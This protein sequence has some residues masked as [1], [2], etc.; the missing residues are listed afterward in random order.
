LSVQG[1]PREA[2]L[3]NAQSAAPI[4]AA[5]LIVKIRG[6]TGMKRIMLV[7]TMAASL[8]IAGCAAPSPDLVEKINAAYHTRFP[9][10]EQTGAAQAPG[11][12]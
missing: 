8:A 10:A 6:Y 4:A 9:V 11:P 3:R 5:A 2:K 1:K 12:P 7:V